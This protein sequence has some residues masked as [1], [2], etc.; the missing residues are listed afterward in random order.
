MCTYMT[1]TKLGSCKVLVYI[2]KILLI[3]QSGTVTILGNFHVKYIHQSVK[4]L[5][6]VTYVHTVADL[7]FRLVYKF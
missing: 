4:I 2:L 7:E 5:F 6:K 3:R 1:V